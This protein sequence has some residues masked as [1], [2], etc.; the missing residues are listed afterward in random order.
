MHRDGTRAPAASLTVVQADDLGGSI[1]GSSSA[2]AVVTGGTQRC[3]FE[4]R[5]AATLPTHVETAL[6]ATKLRMQTPSGLR[7]AAR[8]IQG[9]VRRASTHAVGRRAPH[10]ASSWGCPRWLR[11][12]CASACRQAKT[13]VVDSYLRP[14][15]LPR[16]QLLGGARGTAQQT[17]SSRSNTVVSEME[18]ATGL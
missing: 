2:T 6:I 3:G 16:G 9:N 14:L 18:S 17:C 13:P 4:A 15:L 12:R 8:G 11:A 10:V 7:A 5:C 1:R